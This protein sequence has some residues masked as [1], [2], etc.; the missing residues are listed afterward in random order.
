MVQLMTNNLLSLE[1]FS[2][3]YS[4]HYV[5]LGAHFTD[6]ARITSVM[7]L[8]ADSC[9]KHVNKFGMFVRKNNNMPY[10]LKL[11]VLNAALTSSM[12]YGCETWLIN[13]IAPVAKHY[14][15]ALK[16]LLGVRTSTPNML[17]M[18]ECGQ[19]EVAS[20]IVKR[21]SHFINTF[22][23]N[24]SGDEPLLHALRLCQN[25]NSKMYQI[26]M[27]AKNYVGD[28]EIDSL[29]RLKA[30]CLASRSD[31]TRSATYLDM[32]PRLSVHNIYSDP[33]GAI[34][35]HMRVSF[36]RFR[37]SSHRLRMVVGYT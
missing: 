35:D 18:I 19:A 1:I 21:R 2:V 14:H 30:K 15:T 3:G 32:N 20:I 31:S 22:S 7:K 24:A 5:Y 13:N 37:L 9:A 11:K 17:S 26:L 36:T 34:P 16:L 10:S 33:A 8:H 25:V 29:Q 28:P 12:L 6:D 23:H 27:H 4:D